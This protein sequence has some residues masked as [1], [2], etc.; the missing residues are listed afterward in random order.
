LFQFLVGRER[1]RRFGVHH[2]TSHG[3]LDVRLADGQFVAAYQSPAVH[4]APA[5]MSLGLGA[6]VS[7]TPPMGRAVAAHDVE[8]A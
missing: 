6:H 4:A 7:L 8:D 3:V 5:W 2:F 1:G